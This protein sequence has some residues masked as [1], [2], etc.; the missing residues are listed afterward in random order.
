M[1]GLC[2]GDFVGVGVGEKGV[3]HQPQASVELSGDPEQDRG[4]DEIISQHAANLGTWLI[5]FGPE[6]SRPHG[7]RGKEA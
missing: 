1:L 4:S 7:R 6:L 3:T 5:S 2:W